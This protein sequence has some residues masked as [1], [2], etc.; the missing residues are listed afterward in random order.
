MRFLIIISLY[1][2]YISPMGAQTDCSHNV[3]TNY[4]DH[5]GIDSGSVANWCNEFFC[6]NDEAD[7][8]DFIGIHRADTNIYDNNLFTR[9]EESSDAKEHPPDPSRKETQQKKATAKKGTFNDAERHLLLEFAGKKTHQRHVAA[10]KMAVE[11]KEGAKIENVRHE[12]AFNRYVKLSGAAAITASRY[13][14]G[15]RYAEATARLEQTAADDMKRSIQAFKGYLVQTARGVKDLKKSGK[16]IEHIGLVDKEMRT[17][18]LR[19]F[20]PL[21]NPEG[22]RERKAAARKNLVK[23]SLKRIGLGGILKR[24]ER[25][26][27]KTGGGS[28]EVGGRLKRASSGR[29]KAAA[30]VGKAGNGRKRAAERLKKV[31]GGLKKAGT[32]VMH[33]LYWGLP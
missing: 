18:M 4:D 14:V 17:R 5:P 29:K 23:N 25:T 24:T 11:G 9:S 19:S 3:H 1:F 30:G 32:A 16:D 10:L 12:K 13:G 2:M 33:W 6:N 20:P 27:K 7:L 8:F 22:A 21:P 15:S 26:S 31:G 28:K